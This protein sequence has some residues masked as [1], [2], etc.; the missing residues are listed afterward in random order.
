M[1]TIIEFLQEIYPL[2]DASAEQL[3]RCFERKHYRA[4]TV[5]LKAGEVCKKLY[6]VEKGLARRFEINEHGEDITSNFM[7]EFDI[8][9]SPSSF[10][11]QKPA[12]DN[13]ELLEN[14]TLWEIYYQDLK[15]LQSQYNDI[16]ML[17][18][19]ILE[20]VPQRYEHRIRQLRDLTTKEYYN[21]F[22]AV[23]PTVAVRAQIQHI[24]TYLGTTPN[25]LSRVRK[26]LLELQLGLNC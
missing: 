15:L 2:T 17:S 23:F 22:T 19:G 9:Q 11:S 8:I 7:A 14:S 6:F 21:Y 3:Q 26:E 1:K 10:F 4:A 5:L 24:A 20:K 25:N 12:L 18:L 16:A 13:I